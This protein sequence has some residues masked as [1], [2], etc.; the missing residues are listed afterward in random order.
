MTKT[1]PILRYLVPPGR[2]GV[3][4]DLFLPE[5]VGLSRR[6]ARALISEGAVWRNGKA[7]RVQSRRLDWGDVIDIVG[8]DI[9]PENPPSPP[10]P[11]GVVFEDR[12]L[13][14]VDKPA[15]VL[16]QPS[17]HSTGKELAL[18]QRVLL[19]LAWTGGRRPFLRTI[20][21]LDRRTSGL[22]VF[23]RNR[24]VLPALDR[25]WRSGAVERLYLALVEGEPAEDKGAVDAP[26]GRDRN[27]AW[28]FCVDPDGKPART[29]YRVLDRGDR[30]SA[31]LCRLETGRT[32]QVRVHLAELGHPVAGDRLY[33]GDGV[34]APRPLLHAW[35][36]AFPH[37][38]TG[39]T[40]SLTAPIPDDLRTRLSDG[41]PDDPWSPA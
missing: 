6:R 14:V 20:H 27:H 10:D 18:D 22:V 33:G 38:K 41:F 31:L 37:P 32:H 16:T 35:G 11:I 2:D 28:R 17:E 36:M 15:G 34:D 4:L 1:P 26:I 8:E 19:R 12:S 29:N 13:I 21:R 3:R 9:A 7:V 5:T 40:L 39:E 30:R 24:H 23:A 25:A